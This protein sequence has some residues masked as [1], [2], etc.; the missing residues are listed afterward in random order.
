[1][2]VEVAACPSDY[3]SGITSIGNSG[4]GNDLIT[5]DTSEHVLVLGSG[6]SLYD[7][8]AC[9]DTYMSSGWLRCHSG[10]FVCGAVEHC[11]VAYG[12]M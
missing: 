1:M 8:E 3:V 11:M 2:C 9:G 10:D 12:H 7:L 5:C 4:Y 6:I